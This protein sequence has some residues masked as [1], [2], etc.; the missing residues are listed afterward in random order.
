MELKPCPFCGTKPVREII[1]DIVG[2]T[3]PNCVSVGFHSHVRLGCLSDKQW[4]TRVDAKRETSQLAVTDPGEAM[5][6]KKL[7]D[8][9]DY[10]KQ[11]D[12]LKDDEV[13]WG[14]TNINI[15]KVQLYA[16]G[17]DADKWLE[18]QEEK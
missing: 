6:K 5:L 4:D 7:L 13:L 16:L 11:E 10:Y 12:F 15:I 14:K 1:N 9:C 2:V 17:I 3:C 8:L 18:E